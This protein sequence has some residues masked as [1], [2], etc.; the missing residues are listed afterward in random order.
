MADE[1]SGTGEEKRLLTV[2]LQ[3]VPFVSADFPQP[4]RRARLGPD[5]QPHDAWCGL[6]A[7]QHESARTLQRCGH[8]TIGEMARDRARAESKDPPFVTLP[9]PQGR[10]TRVIITE[11]ELPRLELRRMTWPAIEGKHLVQPASQLLYRPARSEHRCRSRNFMCRSIAPT[12]FQA[13]IGFT[14]IRTASCG[15]RRTG[16]TT[17][18]ASI[19]R[20]RE[21]KRVPWN[22]AEPVNSPMGGNTRLRSGRVHL[23][24]ARQSGR[25]DRCP[26]RRSGR[27][28]SPQEVCRHLRQRAEQGRSLFRRR[29]MAARRFVVVDTDRRGIRARL[30]APIPVRR[31]ESLIRR[32]ITGRPAAAACW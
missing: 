9:R 14:W 7:D 15:V 25:Q 20:P 31:A 28:P 26:D 29:R 24:S 10:Q 21:F 27:E 2:Q 1:L 19:R 12:R 23:E 4:L 3:L 6:A 32:E 16:R 30:Q 11:Y 17:S 5:H 22:V 13:R 8:G 18:G